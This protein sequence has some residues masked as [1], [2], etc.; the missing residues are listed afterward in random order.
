MLVKPLVNLM[1]MLCMCRRVCRDREE[2]RHIP[3]RYVVVSRGPDVPSSMTV[4][5]VISGA[6]GL[7]QNL[8]SLQLQGLGQGD[9]LSPSVAIAAPRGIWSKGGFKHFDS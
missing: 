3:R 6:T 9:S 8:G 1:I 4:T 2:R 5:V 7:M